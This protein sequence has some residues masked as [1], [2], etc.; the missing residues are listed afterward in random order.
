VQIDNLIRK[1]DEN[2]HIYS[3][4]VENESKIFSQGVG[5]ECAYTM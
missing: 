1:L 3:L 5:A 4:F 2:Q